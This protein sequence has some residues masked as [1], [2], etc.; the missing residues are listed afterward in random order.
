[1][2][3]FKFLKVVHIVYIYI[4]AVIQNENEL[5]KCNL[6]YN[7]LTYFAPNTTLTKIKIMGH[8]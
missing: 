8:T 1:M 7:N 2:T 3:F 5:T 4:N 6:C